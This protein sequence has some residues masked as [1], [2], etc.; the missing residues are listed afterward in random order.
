[1]PMDVIFG[2]AGYRPQE[3]MEMDYLGVKV[4]VS[5]DQNDGYVISRIISTSPKAYLNP[6]LQPGSRVQVDS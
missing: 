6:K 2:D 5:R 1:M 4:Q 3:T